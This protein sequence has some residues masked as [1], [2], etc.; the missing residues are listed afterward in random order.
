M[1]EIEYGIEPVRL[2]LARFLHRKYQ[3][4]EIHSIKEKTSASSNKLNVRNPIQDPI[5]ICV[6]HN[7]WSLYGS[8]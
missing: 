1:F 5:K 3:V 6:T 4:V 7:S 8:A 2:L